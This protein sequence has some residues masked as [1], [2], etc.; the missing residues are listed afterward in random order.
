MIIRYSGFSHRTLNCSLIRQSLYTKTSNGSTTRYGL[1]ARKILAFSQ[2]NVNT[3]LIFTSMHKMSIGIPL[4]HNML[5]SLIFVWLLWAQ[6]NMILF[7]YPLDWSPDA[8]I[9]LNYTQWSNTGLLLFSF[10]KFSAIKNTLI[11]SERC[12][13]RQSKGEV[14][15]LINPNT[16]A[17]IEADANFS[18]SSNPRRN[19][20]KKRL[21]GVIHAPPPPYSTPFPVPSP[22]FTPFPHRSLPSS[23]E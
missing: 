4:H 6:R 17:R 10:Q 19:Y 9:A 1:T 21:H 15:D 7:P 5:D 13:G 14:T 3:N 2:Y 8:T 20:L 11:K 16:E 23:S 22:V 12:G 18:I